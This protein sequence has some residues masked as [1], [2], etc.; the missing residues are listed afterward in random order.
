MGLKF[1]SSVVFV[2]DIK[3]SRQFY[4]DFLQL[5]IADD[6]GENIAYHCGL[7]IWQSGH[8]Y[9][10]IFKNSPDELVKENHGYSHELYFETDNIDE[11]FEEAAKCKVKI[12]HGITNQP[13][14]Q[15]VFRVYDPDGNIVEI[16]E[17]M[18]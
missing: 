4:E 13:W 18:S 17:I 6:Y 15:K 10:N 11:V 14:S 8:A 1:I 2:K 12:M 16:G 5:K 3:T 7:S 9:D